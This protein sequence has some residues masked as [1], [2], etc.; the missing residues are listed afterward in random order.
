MVTLVWCSRVLRI[1][2]VRRPVPLVVGTVVLVGSV[3]ACVSTV[4]YGSVPLADRSPRTVLSSVKAHLMDG[5]TIIFSDGVTV[6]SDL[7]TGPGARYD[8]RLNPVGTVSGIAVDSVLAMESFHT[9]V[10]GTRSTWWGIGG[11]IL[12]EMVAIV[13]ICMFDE[14]CFDNI[15]FLDGF[16]GFDF[17]FP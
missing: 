10:D 3:G 8:I 9:E 16:D 15:V 5:S 4:Q 6:G 12:Y 13:V 17:G 7:L 2:R 14:A 11:F 1:L